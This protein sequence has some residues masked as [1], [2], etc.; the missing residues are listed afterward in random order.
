MCVLIF[1]TTFVCNISHCRKNWARYDHKCTLVPMLSAS[2][3]C[4]NLIELQFSRQIFEKSSNSEFH[5]NHSS[6]SW[7]IPFG[8]TDR[9][10]EA[11]RCLLQF[12]ECAYKNCPNWNY[13]AVNPH[14][15]DKRPASNGQDMTART[16]QRTKTVYTPSNKNPSAWN[17]LSPEPEVTCGTVSIII[18]VVLLPPYLRIRAVSLS[19]IHYNQS[20][21][22]YINR[23][24]QYICLAS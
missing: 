15:Q 13:L 18:R 12:C 3:S 16:S 24:Q 1:S 14:P 11:N 20:Q 6:G 21:R 4:L 2:Y 9:H 22:V 7:A 5:E 10:D 8:E 17:F 19:S 23:R